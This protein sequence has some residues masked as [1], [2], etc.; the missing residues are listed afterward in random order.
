MRSTAIFAM[1]GFIAALVQAL[2]QE[3]S[4][5]DTLKSGFGWGIGFGLLGWGI[6]R[7]A[8]SIAQ[9]ALPGGRNPAENGA[10]STEEEHK[11]RAWVR[12]P[13]TEG[14]TTSPLGEAP[15]RDREQDTQRV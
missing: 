5:E 8:R 1:F 11:E 9:E 15:S 4:L 12:P 6:G 7:V 2:G 3:Q 13:I 14:K 10:V